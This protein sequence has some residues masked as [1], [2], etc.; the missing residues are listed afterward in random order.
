MCNIDEVWAHC[1]CSIA[2]IAGNPAYRDVTELVWAQL[3]SDTGVWTAA[4]GIANTLALAF[5]TLAPPRHRPRDPYFRL[6]PRSN[7]AL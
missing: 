7:P 6:P 1:V 4:G 5:G 2:E 3:R